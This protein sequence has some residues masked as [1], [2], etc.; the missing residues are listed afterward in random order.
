MDVKSGL[1]RKLTDVVGTWS[2][3]DVLGNIVIASFTSFD[4]PP[5]LV[6]AANIRISPYSAQNH[7]P[8]NVNQKAGGVA[9]FSLRCS[10]P[11]SP[12]VHDIPLNVQVNYFRLSAELMA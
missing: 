6:M 5:Q 1:I 8:A 3:L 10:P 12:A 2:V 4:L 7:L 9:A 11:A